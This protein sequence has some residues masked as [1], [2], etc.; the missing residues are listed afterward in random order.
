MKEKI[1]VILMV[2]TTM[3]PC[4]A[5]AVEP[6]GIFSIN[7]TL[8][9]L[10]VVGFE[11]PSNKFYRGNAFMAFKQGEVY[12]CSGGC[13]HLNCYHDASFYKYID[14]PLVSIA[15]SIDF[16]LWPDNWHYQVY[17]MQP[18]GFGFF[19]ALDHNA[20]NADAEFFYGIGIMYKLQEVNFVFWE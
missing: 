18:S 11:G 1:L 16:D 7:E 12:W 9:N 5:Q 14:T 13:L 8:W 3:M 15:Y 2:V 20:D 6:E 10:T 17:V 4:L 19:I